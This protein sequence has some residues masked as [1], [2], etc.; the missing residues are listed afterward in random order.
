MVSISL[1]LILEWPFELL[2]PRECG[3]GDTVQVL[4]MD[5]TQESGTSN[6]PLRNLS[7]LLCEQ[8]RAGLLDDERPEVQHPNHSLPLSLQL[9]AS[10]PP[11]EE[12][13]S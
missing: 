6:L 10:H 11:E 1:S 2:W 9:I 7:Y 4:K 12:L 5:L 8:A 13:S 3:G